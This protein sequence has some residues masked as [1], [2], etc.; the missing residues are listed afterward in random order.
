[1]RIKKLDELPAEVSPEGNKRTIKISEYMGVR[2]FGLLVSVTKARTLTIP[3]HYHSK[4]ETI[5]YVLNGKATFTIEG[6]DHDVGPD[7]IVFISPNEKHKI[8]ANDEDC[9][10]IEV[11]SHPEPDWTIVDEK[12]Q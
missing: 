12:S 10:V 11:F 1:M 4:R 9:R 3:Y 7:T 5:F 8:Q 6:K 2:D